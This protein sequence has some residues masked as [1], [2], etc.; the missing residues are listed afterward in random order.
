[1]ARSG[2]EASSALKRMR[3]VAVGELDVLMKR[4]RGIR[5]LYV[6]ME[7]LQMHLEAN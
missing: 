7:L 3:I 1:M 5:L 6:D 4:R 2:Y